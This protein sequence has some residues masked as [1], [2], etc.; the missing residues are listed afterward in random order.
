MSE[1]INKWMDEWVAECVNKYVHVWDR[2]QMWEQLEGWLNGEFHSEL[3]T[4]QGPA[5]GG[6]WFRKKSD[7]KRSPFPGP[8]WAHDRK[9]T[10]SGPKPPSEAQEGWGQRAPF[11]IR[12]SRPW[13]FCGTEHITPGSP[14]AHPAPCSDCRWLVPTQ[15]TAKI[16]G[17]VSDFL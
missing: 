12:A 16:A 13:N 10:P 2:E 17:N 15:S 1:E 11:P 7:A 9:C 5:G 6:R 8:G 14:R 3:W 4:T